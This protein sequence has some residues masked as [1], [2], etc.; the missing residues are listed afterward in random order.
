VRTLPETRYS[1]AQWEAVEALVQILWRA[2]AELRVLFAE[3]GEVDFIEVAQAALRALGDDEA[4]TDLA[5][6][7]DYQVRHLLVDEFQD[8]SL[9]QFQLLRRLT[10]GGQRGDG[11]TLFAVGDPMQSIYRFREAEVGLFLQARAR[12]IGDLPLESLTLSENFRSQSGIVNWVNGTFQGVL[13][14]PEDVD[15]GAVPYAASTAHK[16]AGAVPAVSV[17][18]LFA[19]GKAEEPALVADLVRAR[20]AAG[21]RSIAVLGR[22]RSHLALIASELAARGIPSGAVDIEPLSTRPVVQDLLALT[23]ALSHPGD[24]LAWLAVLRAPCRRRWKAY[25]P[26][27]T[28]GRAARYS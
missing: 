13:C 23:R 11:R 18:P 9:S 26:L 21:C 15:A 1:D 5:L 3:R 19:D 10:A 4:P 17:H 20:L 27:R 25:T 8:T 16:G 6:R 7:L 2:A 14:S 28:P 12:G 24:R 22:S